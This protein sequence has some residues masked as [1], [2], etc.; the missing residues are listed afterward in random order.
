M[1]R[2]YA[3]IEVI[4]ISA[5]L[6]LVYEIMYYSYMF[7]IR[8][9]M[10]QNWQ[11]LESTGY[12]G[13]NLDQASLAYMKD[14]PIEYTLLCWVIV[15]AILIVSTLVTRGRLAGTMHLRF[16]SLRNHLAAIVTALGLVIGFNGLM[17]FLS[18]V[19]QYRIV[20][21]PDIILEGYDIR[22]LLMTVGL[23]TPIA[24]E[25]FFRGL[26]LGRLRLAYGTG[27][28]VVLSSLIFAGSHLNLAQSL[29]VFPLGIICGLLVIETG[30]VLSAVW[31]HVIYNAMNI[32]LAKIQFFQYNSLQLL[33]M[34]VCGIL[35]VAFGM[36]QSGRVNRSQHA[37]E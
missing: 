14:H 4:L 17:G 5:V 33:V 2:F 32:Y 1:K 19:T 18:D 22:Y 10:S 25:I 27:F 16:L 37:H 23:I 20:Y 15:M 24:E 6:Y 11:W 26:L 7:I 13:L 34:M 21:M 3:L 12:E 35:L 8:Y 36:A 30:S 29:V 9:G 28:S 31:L